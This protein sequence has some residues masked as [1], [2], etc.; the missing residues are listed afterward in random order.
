MTELQ[1]YKFIKENEIEC[2]IFKDNITGKISKVIAFIPYFMIE[3]LIELFEDSLILVNREL[4]CVIKEHDLCVE[5][6]QVFEY[7]QIEPENI[8]K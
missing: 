4:E 1:L 2:N 3:D 8:F 6:T 7:F 5:M